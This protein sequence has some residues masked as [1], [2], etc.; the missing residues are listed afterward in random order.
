MKISLRFVLILLLAHIFITGRS[1]N[2]Y[3]LIPKNTGKINKSVLARLPPAFRGLAAF[4]SG[5]GGTGCMDRQCA[6]T[7]ALGLGDQGS[8]D[9]KKIIKKYFPDDKAADLVIG[10]DCYLPP[11]GSSSFSD[12]RYLSFTVLGNNVQVNYELDVFNHGNIKKIRGPDVYLLKNGI[13]KNTKRV[14]YAWVSK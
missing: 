14:L 8:A 11:T 2:T 10:Q 4:Y 3:I 9:Q 5:M 12:F 13:F 1:Q 6:L 7:T